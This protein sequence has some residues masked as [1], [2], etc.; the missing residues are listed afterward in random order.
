[1]TA[2]HKAEQ[3][4]LAAAEIHLKQVCLWLICA[5]VTYSQPRW[6]LG[7]HCT[8]WREQANP[9]GTVSMHPWWYWCLHRHSLRCLSS[10]HLWGCVME[11]GD[12]KK[13]K[14]F[15]DC[16]KNW[17]TS[18]LS[19]LR[20]DWGIKRL[21]YCGSV[22]CRVAAINRLACFIQTFL[23]LCMLSIEAVAYL[24]WQTEHHSAVSWN[25]T[26]SWMISHM[27]I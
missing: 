11:K 16:K 22:F 5:V 6:T 24:C 18:A 8:R 27:R 7:K 23:Q 4:T 10:R 21:C 19:R 17:L 13:K 26:L 2:W 1:M 9:L 15:S 25:D 12:K 3:W 14:S 20:L